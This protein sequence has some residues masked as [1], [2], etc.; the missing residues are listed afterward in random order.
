MRVSKRFKLERTQGE[1]DFVDV[2]ISGDTR[3]YVDPRA[4]RL[5]TTEWSQECVSLIQHF[6]SAVLTEIRDGHDDKAKQLLYGLSEPNETH[7]GLSVGRAKGSGVGHEL[8]D[9]MWEALS[10]TDAAT[11]GLLKD[12]EETALV[13][14]GI[15]KDR[16]SDVA[17]NIIREPLI[18]YTQAAC[19]HYG[20]KLTTGVA[21]GPLWDRKNTAWYERL[22]GLPKTKDGKLI[23]VPKLI[24]RKKLDYRSSEYFDHFLVEELQSRELSAGTELVELLKSGRRRVTKKSVKRKYGTGKEVIAHWTQEYPD[25]LDRY[26]AEKRAH[27]Q[28][29]L[30][31]H[32]FAEAGVGKVPDLK[33]LLAAAVAVKSGKAGASEYHKAIESLL[34]ALFY[35]RLASPEIEYP[36]H[37]GRKRIDIA[38]A[39]AAQRGFFEWLGKHHPCAMIFVECKNYAEDPANP[40]LDQLSGRFSPKRGKVGLLVCRK[41]TDKERMIERCRDT[42]NDDRGFIIA[43]DDRDLATI[44]DTFLDAGDLRLLRERFDA[45]LK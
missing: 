19:E 18:R 14:P 11:T 42:A 26:R 12:L 43:L 31:H 24:V 4:L 44:V 39:N 17:T 25:V 29:P 1:L 13:V 28:S 21:S 45:L 6:F 34:S 38:Y 3:L 35:P 27:P 36:I 23:L 15:D 40:E 41:I 32:D 30:D 8:A 22:E 5:L 33:A 7:L 2:D 9:R 10:E 20:I 16:V 37:N